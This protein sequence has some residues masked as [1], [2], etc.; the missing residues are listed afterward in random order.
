[1]PYVPSSTIEQQNAL[2]QL[3]MQ[4]AT[5][6][7]G[8]R[9]GPLAGLM[10]GVAA[11]AFMGAARRNDQTNQQYRQDFLA[12]LP[13][14]AS[15]LSSYLLGS[16]DPSMQ[17]L[18][19]ELL[20]KQP[21]DLERRLKEAQIRKYEAEAA[22]GGMTPYQQRSLELREQEI[23]NK[24]ADKAQGAAQRREVLVNEMARLKDTAERLAAHPGLA[25]S[26]GLRG[27]LMTIPGTDPADFEAQLET[28]KSQIGFNVLQA[29]RNASQTG[30]A[31]G[32][33][34]VQELVMLQNNL[35]ALDTKQ[36]PEAF[37]QQLRQIAGHAD[38]VIRRLNEAAKIDAGEQPAM[39]PQT[40]PAPRPVPTMNV[41]PDGTMTPT[42]APDVPIMAGASPNPVSQGPLPLPRAKSELQVGQVY[43]FPDG[44][45]GLWVGNGFEP[46]N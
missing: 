30:G 37:M 27:Q 43:T 32:Q 23:G 44:R 12:N 24:R 1:M 18:G 16:Q 6:G 42:Q 22:G 35:G 38:Q 20:A 39:A 46:L 31:L 10:Q 36:S 17:N 13:Q 41:S 26:V 4:R 19:I 21:S 14:D 5:Q 29:M 2:A 28:L 33:V 25:R 34:A 7:Q 11:G 45:Q 9:F 15:S 3:L 40:A 8:G